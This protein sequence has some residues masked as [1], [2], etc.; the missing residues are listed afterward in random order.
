MNLGYLLTSLETAAI[1]AFSYEAQAG[2]SGMAGRVQL[3]LTLLS[4]IRKKL[5]I[6]DLPVCPRLGVIDRRTAR[7]GT[8]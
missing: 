8:R 4:M 7:E 2:G 1:L 5:K 6:W 3:F